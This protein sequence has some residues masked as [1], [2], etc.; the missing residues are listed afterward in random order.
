MALTSPA[1]KASPDAL[2]Y[3]GFLVQQTLTSFLQWLKHLVTH[4]HLHTDNKNYDKKN[5]LI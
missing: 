5:N 3:D 2:D 1:D 4:E